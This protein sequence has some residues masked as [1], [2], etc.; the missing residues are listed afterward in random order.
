MTCPHFLILVVCHAYNVG[1][2]ILNI[3]NL[4]PEIH[5]ALRERA[6]SN[7][8]RMEAEAREI[9]SQACQPGRH[10]SPQ[11]LQAFVRNEFQ[12]KLPANDV[13]NF[14]A[15]RKSQWREE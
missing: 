2:A 4:S 10:I 7:G 1:M 14:L 12:G 5:Q 9:L 13:A 8:R 6:A 15:E 11:D 3:R